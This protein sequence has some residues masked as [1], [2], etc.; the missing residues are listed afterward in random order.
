MIEQINI[1]NIMVLKSFLLK[2]AI[3]LIIFT[4]GMDRVLKLYVFDYLRSVPEKSIMIT[5]FF[6]ITEV[7]N[8]GIS[9]GL[10]RAGSF[11][12]VV[13][14]L[15]MTVSIVGF[16]IFLLLKSQTRLEILAFSCIIGGAL[17]NLYDRIYYGAVYDFLDFHLGGIHFWT[18]NPADAFI[19]VGAFLLIC[20]QIIVFLNRPK[21]K[22]YG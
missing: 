11:L 1:Q 17:G 9:F 21:D 8:H 10:L 6:N 5:S 12:G 4:A 14:L 3:P 20:D 18:F 22:E 7:W 2:I 13:L 19:S 15:V 16:L